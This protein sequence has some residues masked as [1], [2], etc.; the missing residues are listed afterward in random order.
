[1]A[2]VARGVEHVNLGWAVAGWIL[3]VPLL[4]RLAQVIVD[5]LGGGPR[6]LSPPEGAPRWQTPDRS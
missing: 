6:R 3:R 1:V 5:G 2:A 4:D